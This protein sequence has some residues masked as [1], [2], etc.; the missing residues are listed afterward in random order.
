MTKDVKE[1]YDML[2][3]KYDEEHFRQNSAAEYVEKRRLDLIYSYLQRSKGLR[4]LDVAQGTGTY[5]EIAKRIGAEVVGC[6]ISKNMSQICKNKGL[7]NTFVCNYQF[8]P[9]QDK[10]FDLVLCINAI[11]YS[12]IPEQVLSEMRRILSDNGIILFT[13]FNISNFR[14]INYLRKMYKKDRQITYQHRYFFHKINKILKETKLIPFYYCGI[15]LLPFTVNSNPRNKKF[16]N[17]CY[18]I[19]HHINQTPLKHFFNEV[20]FVL[21]KDLNI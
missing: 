15:N 5:L 18:K 7:D 20:F 19:E 4:I 6:D 10:T 3:G 17:I 9:F 8:L 1:I 12:S 13:Y 21:K 11:H 14:G 2:A 16:L